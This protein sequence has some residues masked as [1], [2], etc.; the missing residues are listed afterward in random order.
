MR[1]TVKWRLCCKIEVLVYFWFKR[2]LQK[3]IA[4]SKDYAKA[5]APAGG[6]A[7]DDAYILEHFTSEMYFLGSW[8]AYKLFQYNSLGCDCCLHF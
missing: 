2:L 7:N 5:N 1:N 4:V 3:N 6:Y 8:I